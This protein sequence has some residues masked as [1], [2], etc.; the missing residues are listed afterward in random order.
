VL[1]KALQVLKAHNSVA[2]MIS[3][4]YFEKILWYKLIVCL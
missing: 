2:Q 4:R 3:S 1:R